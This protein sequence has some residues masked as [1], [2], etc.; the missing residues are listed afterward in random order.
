[1]REQQIE[2][3]E[4]EGREPPSHRV[5]CQTSASLCR[6]IYGGQTQSI[7]DNDNPG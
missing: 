5:D 6:V 2:E 7:A 3:G 4:G 1:M